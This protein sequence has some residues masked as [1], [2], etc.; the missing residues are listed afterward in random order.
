[1]VS[2]VQSSTGVSLPKGDERVFRLTAQAA[3]KARELRDREKKGD[4]LRVAVSGGGCN[5]LSYRLKFTDQTKRGDILVD[6][7]GVPVLVDS[8]SVLYLKGTT[9][10]YSDDLVGGGFKFEN[11]R[12]KG[13]C[14]CGESFNL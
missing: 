6:T 2:D 3:E 7:Q 13:S 5:G 9:L 10:A 4:Y 12:A 1:M 14:S 11:P 8:K